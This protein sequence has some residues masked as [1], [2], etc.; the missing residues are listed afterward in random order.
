MSFEVGQIIEGKVTGITKFGAFVDIGEGKTGMVHISEVAPTYVSDINEHLKEGQTVK[1]RILSIG[2][3]GKIS[4]SIKKAMP[5]PA[6]PTGGGRNN[7]GGSAPRRQGGFSGGSNE[8]NPPRQSEPSSF[9]DM[10]SKFKQA[11]DEKISS[12]KRNEGKRG[13]SRRGNGNSSKQ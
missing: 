5:R 12:L 9:E 13:S 1:V 4:L 8:W 2:D 11:S 6:A 10:L 7:R 3:D